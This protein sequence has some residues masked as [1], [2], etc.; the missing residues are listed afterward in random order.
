MTSEKDKVRRE[1]KRVGVYICHCGGNISDHVDVA[2]LAD[3]VKDLEGVVVSHTNT[4]MCS[5][6]G[7]ELIQEDIKSGKVNRV[8][9]ASCAPSLHEITFRGA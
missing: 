6:P 3:N 1:E 9:V 5:D 8:V 4:F 7:Q 2:R